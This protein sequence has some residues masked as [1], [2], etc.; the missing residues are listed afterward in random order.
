MITFRLFDRK[1]KNYLLTEDGIIFSTPL[2]AEAEEYRYDYL[3][4]RGLL[5]YMVV[6]HKFNNQ[7][8]VGEVMN[9]IMN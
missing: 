8:F 4:E 3:Q 7:T 1:T 9:L 5:P 6:I 2:Y